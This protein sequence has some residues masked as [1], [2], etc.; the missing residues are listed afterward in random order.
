MEGNA[1]FRPP[2]E[3]NVLEKK[4]AGSQ[5]SKR[6]DFCNNNTLAEPQIARFL[7]TR[8]SA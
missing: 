7:T 8:L 4:M 6:S 2:A 1:W 5:K 3:K